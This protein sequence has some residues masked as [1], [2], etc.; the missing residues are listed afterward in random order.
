MRRDSKGCHGYAAA[1]MAAWNG[2]RRAML[3]HGRRRDGGGIE[4]KGQVVVTGAVGSQWCYGDG[5]I[6]CL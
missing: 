1:A 6:H 4:A 2:D 5:D 3:Q